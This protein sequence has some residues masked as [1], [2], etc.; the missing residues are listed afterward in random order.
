MSLNGTVLTLALDAVDPRLGARQRS[1]AVVGAMELNP[2]LAATTWAGMLHGLLSGIQGQFGEPAF[3]DVMAAL[4]SAT[5][6]LVDVDT[7]GPVG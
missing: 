1:D 4:T 3:Q 6:G 7:G 2:E 5:V